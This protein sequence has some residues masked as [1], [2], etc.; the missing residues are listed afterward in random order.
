L[1]IGFAA[2]A[3][4]LWAFNRHQA[5]SA[6]LYFEELPDEVLTTLGLIAPQPA[7]TNA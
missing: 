2:V 6:V 3:M 5:K 1:L 4:G 7:K